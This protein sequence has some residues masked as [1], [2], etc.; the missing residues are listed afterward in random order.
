MIGS[1]PGNSGIGSKL[2]HNHCA[3]HKMIL[4][5]ESKKFLKKSKRAGA[6]V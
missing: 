2:C 6:V 5:F 3:T 4:L 1:E